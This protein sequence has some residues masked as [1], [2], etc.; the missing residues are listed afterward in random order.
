MLKIIGWILFSAVLLFGQYD[1]NRVLVKVGDVKITVGEFKKRFE[2]SPQTGRHIKGGLQGQKE[3]LLKTLIAEKLWSKEAEA[4]G[5]DTT[6]IMTKTFKNLE[7]MYVRDALYRSEIL[8]NVKVRPE[9]LREAYFRSRFILHLNYLYSENQNEIFTI[10]YK[11][12]NGA[13]F[14]SLLAARP[15]GALQKETYAVEFGQMDK[16]VEDELYRIKPGH[17]TEPF[18]APE[19]WY[20]FKL[21]TIEEKK[22]EN[23]RQLEVMRKNAE[24]VVHNT[25]ED[26]IYNDYFNSFFT[27]RKITTNGQLFW[28]FADRV[29]KIIQTNQKKDNVTQGEKIHLYDEDLLRIEREFPKDSLYM[30]FVIFNR[31]PITFQEFFRAF[32]FE[33]FYAVSTD[34]DTISSQLNSRVKRFIEQELL[35][36]E[37]AGKNLE[38][39]PEVKDDLEMWRD[40]YL[41]TLLRTDFK[42]S[43]EVTDAELKEMYERENDISPVK[44]NII[45]IL[46]DDLETVEKIFGEIEEGK[47]FRELAVKYTKREWTKKQNGEFGLFAVNTNGEIGRIASNMEIGEIYGPLEV[48][49][50]FSIFKLID[51]TE[52]QKNVSS[53]E[54]FEESKPELVKKLKNEKYLKAMVNK[55]LQFADKYDVQINEELLKQIDVANF[56]MFVY[57]YFGFGGRSVAVPVMV[58]FTEWF[59]PWK[60]GIKVLP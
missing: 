58:P 20:I 39:H 13:S 4:R 41:S 54:S 25:I 49:Q 26:S 15:E 52:E 35:A 6:A 9:L 28:S 16:K 47:D 31:Q 33:G 14:D 59:E 57:K 12:N 51:K 1:D 32:A 36:R 5:F 40:Y 18:Q 17:F 11:L 22:V 50:G 34:P 56:N 30:P 60:S 55:T 37:A 24:K 3:E 27:D 48:K 46:V 53:P 21:V 38:N 8:D 44:V 43:I 2:L 42:D 10:F 23:A 7:K 19:G 45:E 29:T